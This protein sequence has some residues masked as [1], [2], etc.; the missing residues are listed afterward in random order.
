VRHNNWLTR[1][2]E[3]GSFLEVRVNAAEV[4]RAQYSR[5]QAWARRTR[6]GF[7]VF[8][9]SSTEPFLPQEDHYRVTRSVL[10]AMLEQ[11]PDTLVLQ[12]HTHR[13]CNYLELYREL[14]RR[15]ELRLHL[16]IESDRERLPGLPPPASSV[17]RRFE[18][19]AALKKAGLTVVIT[20]SPLLP[21]ED[22]PAFFERIAAT[23]DGVVIDHFIEGDGSPDGSRTMRTALPAAISDVDPAAT[24]LAYR[25]RIVEIA[26]RV[27][28]GR[29]GVSIDGFAG[30][31]G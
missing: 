17:D 15:C 31:M 29:V 25:D 9:S 11:P 23:A 22:A 1:G 5:E 3:W 12:S 7:S 28:P 21:I 26:R 20:V 30:R 14:A 13:I 16:S 27:M 6:G 4:Y 19:C 10:E 24:N 2:A 8:M 18:A